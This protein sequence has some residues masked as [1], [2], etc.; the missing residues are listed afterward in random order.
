MYGAAHAADIG[1]ELLDL[2]QLGENLMEVELTSGP[3][4]NGCAQ[5]VHCRREDIV[6]VC[7]SILLMVF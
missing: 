7:V 3:D 4:G 6:P 1:E 2:P 5:S